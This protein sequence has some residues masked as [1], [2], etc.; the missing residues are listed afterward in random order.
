MVPDGVKSVVEKQERPRLVN[1]LQLLVFYREFAA[2]FGKAARP[3][4]GTGVRVDAVCRVLAWC[5]RG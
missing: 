4:S 3:Q 1:E 5:A 2:G